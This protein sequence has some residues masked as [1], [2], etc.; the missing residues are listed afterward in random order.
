LDFSHSFYVAAF[1]AIERA[2]RDAAVWA[3][4]LSAIEEAVKKKTKHESDL[5]RIDQINSS[6]LQ[7]A[8]SCLSGNFTDKLVINVEPERLN[9][10]LSIQQ[11]LFL[12]PCDGSSSFEQNL[13][14]TLFESQPEI[15]QRGEEIKFS[16]ITAKLI[17][18]V[19]EA[20]VIKI[21]VPRGS[22][23]SALDELAK[24]NITSATLFPGLDGFA[25]SL[26]FHLRVRDIDEEFDLR[27][28]KLKR[29]P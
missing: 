28:S 3:V 20:N 19:S 4:K 7:I 21:I 24:M 1:F 15:F 13:A 2:I 9:E 17:V 25:R 14:A 22:H 11:G 16:E 12:F 23:R 26:L 10:R 6:H 18:S 29:S 5:L 27:W 8:E